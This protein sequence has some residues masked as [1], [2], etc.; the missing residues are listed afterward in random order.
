[1]ELTGLVSYASLVIGGIVLAAL[2]IGAILTLV[3]ITLTII[4]LKTRQILIPGVTLFILN[5][6]EAPIRYAFWFVGFEED[7]VGNMLTEVRNIIYK[8]AF[9]K[10][11]YANR[12]LFLPHCLRSTHCPAPL[13]PEGIKCMDCGRCG[14]GKIKEEAESLGYRVF[15]S[16]GSSLVKRVVKKYRPKAVLGV[17]CSMEV[18]EG[19]AKMA[20]Y[21]LPVQGVALER[22]GCVDTRVDVTKLFAKIKAKPHY[23]FESDTEFLK[24]AVEVSE[25]WSDSKVSEASVI[26]AKKTT[27]RGK[28]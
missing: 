1:M 2:F 22:D 27:E 21:G 15:I 7:V 8:D 28:W 25:L 5:L 4:F 3:G 16:P 6:L 10:T 26:V 18:K 12:A 20:S 24:K 23:S 19:T 9:E 13:T 17:G 14:I 11:P